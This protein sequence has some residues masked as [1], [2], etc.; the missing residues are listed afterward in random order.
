[1]QLAWQA[2]VEILEE[3]NLILSLSL[4]RFFKCWIEVGARNRSPVT[5]RV[6]QVRA[7]ALWYSV[8]FK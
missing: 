6:A 3:I 8:W 7:V 1:M 5:V 2:N 4:S